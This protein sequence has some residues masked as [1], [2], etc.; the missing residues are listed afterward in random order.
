MGY[1]KR[2]RSKRVPIE[3]DFN[4][5]AFSHFKIDF[6]KKTINSSL[7]QYLAIFPADLIA[8]L[9]E[10]HGGRLLE[11]NVRVFFV[12]KPKGKPSYEKHTKR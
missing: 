4:T 2:S 10:R 3:I 1:F 11:N 6:I 7:S 9:Y 5:S 12:C 8:D